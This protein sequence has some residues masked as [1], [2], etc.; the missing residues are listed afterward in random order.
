ML[1]V[2]HCFAMRKGSAPRDNLNT[3]HDRTIQFRI[4]RPQALTFVF[5]RNFAAPAL[6]PTR[7]FQLKAYDFANGM[8]F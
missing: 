8:L 4:S 5:C 2:P 7:F 6:I 1:D 3:E